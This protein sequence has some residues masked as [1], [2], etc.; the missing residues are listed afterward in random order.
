MTDGPIGGAA[1]MHV[2]LRR[3]LRAGAL[4]VLSLPYAEAASFGDCKS[5]QATRG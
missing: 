3:W 2:S 5:S 4:P 1:A